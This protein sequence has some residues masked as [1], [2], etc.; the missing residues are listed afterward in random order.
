MDAAIAALIG[1]AIGVTGTV[2]APIVTS[3]QARRAKRVDLK[4]DAYSAGITAM[5]GTAFADSE[6]KRTEV[7]QQAL[8]ALGDIEMHGSPKAGNLY[9]DIAE[10]LATWVETQHLDEKL[11]NTMQEFLRVA[12]YETGVDRPIAR[13]RNWFLREYGF[14]WPTNPIT[15]GGPPDS[16]GQ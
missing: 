13:L 11:S 3:W 15:N 16:T 4:R 12:R 14:S 10:E 1:A 5:I 9:S 8:S 6:T 7:F 2:V